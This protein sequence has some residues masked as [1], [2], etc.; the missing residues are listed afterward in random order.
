LTRLINELTAVAP[1]V[2]TW[3]ESAAPDTLA[4][5]TLPLREPRRRLATTYSIEHDHMAVRRRTA[6]VRVF[7]NEASF[8]RLA[9]ALAMERNEKW[10]SR[11]YFIPQI[12]HDAE[13][14]MPAA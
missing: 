3:L 6:V 2:A 11:R 8:L 5:Y 1:R 7:P 14:L 4:M 13:A 12:T 9:S 10:L